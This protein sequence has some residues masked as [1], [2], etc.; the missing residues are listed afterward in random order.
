MFDE[1]DEAKRSHELI[2]AL[3]NDG[4]DVAYGADANEDF[5]EHVDGGESA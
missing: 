5:P 2:T 3:R 4:Y 1:E